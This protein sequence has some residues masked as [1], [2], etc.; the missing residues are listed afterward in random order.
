MR[1]GEHALV[2]LRRESGG[3][4]RF[5]D[6]GSALALTVSLQGWPGKCQN[7]HDDGAEG[8]PIQTRVL[9]IF[10]TCWCQLRLSRVL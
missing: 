10:M 9:I 1:V 6:S 8:D 3:L 4:R 7:R 5:A 2:V